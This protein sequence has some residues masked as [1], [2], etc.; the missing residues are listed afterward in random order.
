MNYNLTCNVKVCSKDD[1]NSVCAAAKE[2][3]EALCEGHGISADALASCEMTQGYP[4]YAAIC[5][6]D[7]CISANGGCADVCT[8]VSDSQVE[9][10]CS[11][12]QVLAADGTSCQSATPQLAVVQDAPG[13][14]A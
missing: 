14:L 5:V 12:D 6:E 2:G 7:P 1:Q 9:C 13:Q 8:M 4:D 3:C 11:G 10:S